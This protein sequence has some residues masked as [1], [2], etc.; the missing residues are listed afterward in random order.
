MSKDYDCLSVRWTSNNRLLVPDNNKCLGAEGKTVGSGVGLYD[1]DENSDLQK[2]ECKNQT[3]L[4]L[5]NQDLYI[6]VT[7]YGTGVLSKVA[8]PTSHLTI[9]GVTEGACSRTYRGMVF[10]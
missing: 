10:T 9:N 3:L 8:G 4:A 5:Q 1:C 2:W 7:S 6:N